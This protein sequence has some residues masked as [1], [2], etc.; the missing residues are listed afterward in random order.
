[1]QSVDVQ[2]SASVYAPEVGESVREDI[3]AIATE[4]DLDLGFAAGRR[5]TDL[6]FVRVTGGKFCALQIPSYILDHRPEVD[7]ELL[8]SRFEGAQYQVTL[9]VTRKLSE[10]PALPLERRAKLRRR[11]KGSR[12]SLPVR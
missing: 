12:V 10:Q 9:V 8:S 4:L 5:Q 11:K 3:R 2:P 1:M 6:F 7:V